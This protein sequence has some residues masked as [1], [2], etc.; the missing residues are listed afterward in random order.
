MAQP[1]RLAAG[2]NVVCRLDK[3]EADAHGL[4]R[5]GTKG[6]GSGNGTQHLQM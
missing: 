3:C 4:L 5:P 6:K 2:H 1:K